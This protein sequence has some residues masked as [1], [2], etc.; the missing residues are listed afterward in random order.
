MTFSGSRV[1]G[2]GISSAATARASKNVFLKDGLATQRACNCSQVSGSQ[3]AAAMMQCLHL[4]PTGLRLAFCKHPQS[5]SCNKQL[6]CLQDV[7]F[8]LHGFSPSLC[9]IRPLM[10]LATLLA[11]V[12]KHPQEHRQALLTT[13]SS[14][15][16]LASSGVIAELI[17]LQA[18][19]CHKNGHLH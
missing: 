9:L 13:G 16:L 5:V 11:S 12:M 7:C 17:L 6:W 2:F 10:T 15:K 19:Q 3:V 18:T 14:N 1:F 8:N 4:L